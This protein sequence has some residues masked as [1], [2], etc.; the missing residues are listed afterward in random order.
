M[1]PPMAARPDRQTKSLETKLA[2]KATRTGKPGAK[3]KRWQR[4]LARVKVEGAPAATGRSPF[5]CRA[6]QN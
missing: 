5:G 4:A 3:A 1:R 6:F 2:R